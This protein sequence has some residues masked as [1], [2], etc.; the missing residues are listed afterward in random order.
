MLSRLEPENRGTEEFH[1]P[2]GRPSH[3][4]VIGYHW[5]ARGP[6]LG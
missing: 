3:V 2:L 1:S 5:V 6:W 4:L